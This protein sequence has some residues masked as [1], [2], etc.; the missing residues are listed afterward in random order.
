MKKE[1]LKYL[2]YSADAI[3][4][5]NVLSLMDNALREVENQA[6]FRYV[7]KRFDTPL[8][9]MNKVAAYRDYVGD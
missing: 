7:Y 4:D 9:F 6:C 5:D 3:V 8:P 1:I 2:G